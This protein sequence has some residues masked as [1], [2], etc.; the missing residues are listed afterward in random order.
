MI[1][2]ILNDTEESHLRDSE[3][4]SQECKESLSVLENEKISLESENELLKKEILDLKQDHR[5]KEQLLEKKI[6]EVS[7]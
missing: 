7:E 5:A 2:H 6:M 4:P 1:G 3:S